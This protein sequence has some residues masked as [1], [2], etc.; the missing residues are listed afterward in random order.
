MGLRVA[1]GGPR[2]RRPSW[3]CGASPIEL[4]PDTLGKCTLK[5]SRSSMGAP[6]YG[7]GGCRFDPC[8]DRFWVWPSSSQGSPRC[9]VGGPAAGCQLPAAQHFFCLSLP[10]P[11]SQA[12]KP[13]HYFSQPGFRALLSPLA[14]EEEALAVALLAVAAAR[15]EIPITGCGLLFIFCLPSC[16]P[17]APPP[18][19]PPP[20]THPPLLPFS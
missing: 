10:S 18:P 5:R 19:P 14:K 16:P 15:A 13:V 11:R 2:C 1:C 17:H 6:V 20:P 4:R 12:P 3:A 8:R 9:P 7:T